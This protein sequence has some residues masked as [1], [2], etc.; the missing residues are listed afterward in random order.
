MPLLEKDNIEI[1]R[2]WA[3]SLFRLLSFVG[4]MKAYSSWSSEGIRVKIIISNRKL[5]WKITNSTF[6]NHKFRSNSIEICVSVIMRMRKGGET[7]VPIS[8]INDKQSIT[9][10]F[11]ITLDNR[12][13]PTQLICKGKTNESLLEV[14]FPEEFL[15]SANETKLQ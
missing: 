1:G 6:F 4:N 9:A 11:S 8:S 13:L 2:P 10:T 12:F 5:C 7:N 14:T 3:Q 15:L